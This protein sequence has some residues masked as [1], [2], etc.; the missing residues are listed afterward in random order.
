V[1]SHRLSRPAELGR[2]RTNDAQPIKKRRTRESN[3]K[4]TDET[5]WERTH[6]NREDVGVNFILRAGRWC[7][8]DQ[9]T[10]KIQKSEI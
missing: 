10:N 9:I 8:Q 6:R 7:D 4:L 5:E 3:Q 2:I 1:T